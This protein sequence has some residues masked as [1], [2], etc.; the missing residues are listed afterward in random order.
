LPRWPWPPP[1]ARHP[2]EI[3]EI[4]DLEIR[5]PLLVGD[6]R[7]TVIRSHIDA[8]DGS[9]T[10]RGREQ[11]GSDP[12]AL[13]CVARV[14]REAQYTLLR[15]SPPLL[16]PT[17]SPDFDAASHATL[18]RAV[19]IAYGPAF[20]C[21]EHGWIE[22]NS[23]LAVYR[24]PDLVASQLAQTC[25]CIRPCSMAHSSWSSSCCRTPLPH[26]TGWPSC[27]R[28]W[29]ASLSAADWRSPGLLGRPC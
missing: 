21:I 23:A 6:E 3:A 15:Q 20:Q 8:P 28:E 7:S 4:E 17:R 10:I 11:L 13:H 22:G 24:I 29:D 5:S 12:W 2:G 25:I 18:T 26:T 27:R 14:L 16:L 19:G 9:L 1:L